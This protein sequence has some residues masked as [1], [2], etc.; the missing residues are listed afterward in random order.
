MN[1]K[2]TLRA[3]ALAAMLLCVGGLASAESAPARP[4]TVVVPYSAGGDADLSARNLSAGVR[5][6]TGE[7]LVVVNKAGAGGAIGSQFVRDAKPNGQTLLLGRVGAQAI[8]PALQPD[9]GYKWNDFTLLGL[10]ELNPVV[11]VVRT[12]A[13]YK[14]LDDLIA[15]IRSQPGKLNYSTSGPGTVLNLTTQALLQSARLDKQAVV[16]VA[17][18]GGGEATAAVL[19]GEVDFTCN[20]LTALIGN[21]KGGKLRALV[22]TSPQRLP[23]LPDVPTASET[24][25]P[26]LEALNGWSALYG[27]P[28]M[29]PALVEKWAAVLPKVASDPQWKTGVLTI[30]SIPMILS[31]SDTHRFVE[32]QVAMYEQLGKSLNIQ[33][34]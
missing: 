26:R 20:N 17:Y 6:V 24:G 9:L 21:I 7:T 29:D 12:A 22:T 14:T 18:K 32:A 34:K 1:K 3:A 25:H 8:L 16:Q 33:L 27:P 19:S 23:E 28:G 4:I 2:K 13:A 31:P 11:C 30:A 5:N 15:V 10:L